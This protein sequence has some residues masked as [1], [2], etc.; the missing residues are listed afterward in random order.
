M[1]GEMSPTETS[2]FLSYPGRKISASVSVTESST[3]VICSW[4]PEDQISLLATYDITNA[5]NGKLGLDIQTPFASYKHISG[6]AEYSVLD[7][8]MKADVSNALH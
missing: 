6:Q 4:S 8:D 5:E 1:S 2:G 7:S 3:Q